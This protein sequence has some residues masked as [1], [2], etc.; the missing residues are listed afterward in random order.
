MLD[1]DY[2]RLVPPH[3]R[4]AMDRLR[5][6]QAVWD[7]YRDDETVAEMER[8]TA[9]RRPAL[10]AA[11]SKLLTLG[12]WV[13]AKD[14]KRT[15]GKIVRVIIATAGYIVDRGDVPIAGDPLFRKGTRYRREPAKPNEALSR[16]L[17]LRGLAPDLVARLAVRAAS[18][19]RAPEAE[20]VQIL[21][22]AL[23]PDRQRSGLEL[24]EAIHR[25]F[26]AVGGVEDLPLH[27]PVPA[28]PPSNFDP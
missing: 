26:A 1:P 6:P 14:A 15:F 22:D 13:E 25:R 2:R 4:A 20:A 12:N 11:S 18:N 19:R 10:S 28:E 17:Q 23:L 8:L 9:L 21:A 7:I 3:V 5:D 16:T 24:A 27:P